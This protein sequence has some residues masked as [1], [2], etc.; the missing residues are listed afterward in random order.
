MEDRKAHLG[1][2][3]GAR[4][5]RCTARV[6]RTGEYRSAQCSNKATKDP[7]AE[8]K[9]TKCG[10]HSDEAT[11]RR[12]KKSKERLEKAMLNYRQRDERQKLER[13]APAIIRQIAEGHNDPRSLCAAWLAKWEATQ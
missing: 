2:W 3:N 4:F 13:E 7:D 8:G 12:D 10:T 9:P 5:W 11:A 1:W 6:Y